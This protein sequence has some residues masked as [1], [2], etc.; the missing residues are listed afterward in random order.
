MYVSGTR[1]YWYYE[2]GSIQYTTHAKGA[3]KVIVF[4]NISGFDEQ[5]FAFVDP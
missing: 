3:I 5:S 1:T 4:G 2:G